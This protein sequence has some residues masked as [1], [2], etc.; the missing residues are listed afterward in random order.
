MP[1]VTSKKTPAFVMSPRDPSAACATEGA[2]PP[3]R[4][5]AEKRSASGGSSGS[6]P[7]KENERESLYWTLC[8]PGTVSDGGAFPQSRRRSRSVAGGGIVRTA[9]STNG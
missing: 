5:A 9:L 8:S 4:P 2:T 1:A 7:D 3:H 6:D